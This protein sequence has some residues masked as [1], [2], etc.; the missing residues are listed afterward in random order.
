LPTDSGLPVS[1][2][3]QTNNLT[4][5]QKLVEASGLDDEFDGLMNVTF[6]V[7]NDKA[8]EVSPTGQY[9]ME[10]FEENADSLKDNAE[11]KE[12]LEYHIAEPLTKTCDLS[13]NMMKAKNGDQLRI[14]LYTTHPV[15]VNVM[16][17]ATVNCARL[18]HFDDETCGS[19]VHQVDKVLESPKSVSFIDMAK[20]AKFVKTFL[21]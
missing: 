6:F 10:Q 12:F 16:N 9:W 3:L 2:A 1:S 17:R 13:E 11:L 5:F 4:I 14:N 18:I 20:L 19:V 8:F 15:F 7:P 21:F